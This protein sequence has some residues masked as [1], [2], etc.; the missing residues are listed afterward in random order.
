MVLLTLA[1][2]I[3]ILCNP[4]SSRVQ[5]I[6]HVVVPAAGHADAVEGSVFFT[7]GAS[8]FAQ[9][10][11]QVRTRQQIVDEPHIP[12]VY[13]LALSG[14]HIRVIQN[15]LQV[16]SNKGRGILLS[17]NN[18]V[19]D[20]GNREIQQCYGEL[21]GL[22]NRVRRVTQ[23]LCPAAQSRSIGDIEDRQSMHNI[24]L[25]FGSLV[26]RIQ[27]LDDLFTSIQNPSLPRSRQKLL[28]S[29]SLRDILGVQR[30]LENFFKIHDG[31][32]YFLGVSESV[33]S[34]RVVQHLFDRYSGYLPQR[35]AEWIYV[36]C[37]WSGNRRLIG[38]RLVT[39]PSDLRLKGIAGIEE[40]YTDVIEAQGGTNRI[41]HQFA[42]HRTGK[43]GI[44]K[45]M[46]DGMKDRMKKALEPSAHNGKIKA[47]IKRLAAR[48][49]I[50][51]ARITRWLVIKICFKN[52]T[53]DRKPWHETKTGQFVERLREEWIQHREFMQQSQ[54]S[55][56]VP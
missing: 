19:Q 37:K 24:Y 15:A 12:I 33:D 11:E 42:A 41:L 6:P 7:S 55:E 38:G 34:Q 23:E 36:V 13:S 16:A 39:L 30:D 29:Q 56:T 48:I 10:D 22:V 45:R 31:E 18:P 17:Q 46:W 8:T 44:L 35:F 50:N 9:E 25:F 4:D 40:I 27:P 20:L 52:G 2:T 26:Q 54:E 49:F 43:G 32:D 53:F 47:C 21:I 28:L 5:V 3:K 14:N 51:V 1:C